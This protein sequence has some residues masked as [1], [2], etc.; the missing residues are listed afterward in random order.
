MSTS[1]LICPIRIFLF[2]APPA[3]LHIQ[4]HEGQGNGQRQS[5]QCQDVIKVS[6]QLNPIHNSNVLEVH[7]CSAFSSAERKQN[8]TSGSFIVEPPPKDF[9][10]FRFLIG[11]VFPCLRHAKPHAQIRQER[12]SC[13]HASEGVLDRR[14]GANN[15]RL[16]IFRRLSL[17]C[18]VESHL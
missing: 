4:E 9:R 18:R 14:Q 2:V 3:P 10:M 6:R 5:K 11:L 15:L 8:P 17:R 13:I 12:L 16:S 7:D 1:I